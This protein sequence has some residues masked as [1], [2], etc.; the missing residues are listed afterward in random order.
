MIGRFLLP[1][2]FA[3]AVLTLFAVPGHTEMRN[4]DAPLLTVSGNAGATVATFTRAEME[5]LPQR[6]I[7]TTTTW[8]DGVQTFTG[9][10]VR[11]VLAAAGVSG[12]TARAVALND[13]AV[14]IPASDFADYDVILALRQNGDEMSVR[15]KGP[16]WIVYPRDDHAELQKVEE[17][18]KWI[19]Q[20]SRIELR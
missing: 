10:L 17:N 3:A 19:W 20:L 9:P 11:D 14:D 1:A 5:A 8:T 6:E 15:D 7:R 13:Y 12:G 18:S 16:I 4:G 2:V